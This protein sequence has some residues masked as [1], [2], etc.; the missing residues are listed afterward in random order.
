MNILLSLGDCN[1]LGISNC[2][3][4]SYPEKLSKKLHLKCINS[5]FTMSTTCEM[6]YLFE[7]YNSEEVSIVT[8]QYGLVDSWRTFRYSPYVLYY[9]DNFLRKVFRKIVKK[10]KKIATKVGLDK[11]FGIKYVVSPN[12]YKDNLIS[13]IEQTDKPILLIDTVPHTQMF[14]NKHIVKYNAILEQLSYDYDNCY[15]VK[16]Y[17]DFLINIKDYLMDDGTHINN[18]GYKLILDKIME[19]VNECNIKI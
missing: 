6:K 7:K 9:P 4:N 18:D 8:I 10:Y 5:G 19:K 13:I 11:L 15:Y 3:N 14:R 16:I 1:T 12:L 17:D 2:V